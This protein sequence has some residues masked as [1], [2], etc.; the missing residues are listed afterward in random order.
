[1]SWL[2]QYKA[3]RIININVNIILASLISTLGAT[4]VVTLTQQWLS[5]E[6]MIIIVT[7][8]A[9]AIFN[10]GSFAALHAYAN[11]TNRKQLIYDTALVQAH[12]IVLSPLYY[13]IG[14]GGQA[15]L[16]SIGIKVQWSIILA[17]VIAIAIS[18]VLHTWYCVRTGFFDDTK[19]TN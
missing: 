8:I 19:Y 18:R 10:V 16:L 4:L 12:R 5:T 1:M 14:A 13:G 3:K 15:I 17:Y 6:L 9:D 2:Q 11:H 7:A